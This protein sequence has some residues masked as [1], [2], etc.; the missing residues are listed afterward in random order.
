MSVNNDLLNKFS[1][2]NVSGKKY[3]PDRRTGRNKMNRYNP[4]QIPKKMLRK[5]VDQKQKGKRA[6][7]KRHMIELPED[8]LM[9]IG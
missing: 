8:V 9:N 7:F 4:I 2:L 1:S 6:K 3:G 5:K